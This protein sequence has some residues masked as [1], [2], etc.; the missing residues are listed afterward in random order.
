MDVAIGQAL[1]MSE[2]ERR[3]RM[4]AMQKAVRHYDLSSWGNSIEALLPRQQ[5]DAA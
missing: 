5:K 4:A 1:D 2:T 3:D